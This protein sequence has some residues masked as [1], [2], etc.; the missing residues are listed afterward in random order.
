MSVSKDVREQADDLI[1][2]YVELTTFEALQIA[3]KIVEI[4]AYKEAN[5]V[6]RDEAPTALEAIATCLG[7]GRQFSVTIT[8]AVNDVARALDNV[9]NAIESKKEA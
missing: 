3:T 8:D 5:M 1:E 4:E 2:R 6:G 7:Q 9:A